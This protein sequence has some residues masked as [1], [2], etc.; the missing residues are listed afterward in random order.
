MQRGKLSVMVNPAGTVYNPVSV[1]NTLDGITEGKIFTRSDLH[2][3]DGMWL[4][5][6]HYSDFSSEDPDIALDKIN[7]KRVEAS[8]FLKQAGYLFITFGTARV[9]RWKQNGLIVSNCHKIPSDRFNH[10]LLSVHEIE[11]IWIRQLDKLSMLYPNL[12]IIFT[13]SPVRHLKD[14]AHGN[15]VSKSVLFLAVERLLGHSSGPLYF[16]AYEILMD[17]LRDYRFYDDD[18]VHPSGTA[19]NYIWDLFS[20]SFIDSDALKIWKEV[21][22]ITKAC[23]HRFLTDSK[24]KKQAFARKMLIHI[25]DMENRMPSVDFSDEKNY[26]LGLVKN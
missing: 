18:M 16:P 14:G 26:F 17:D 10:E 23:S 11:D 12:K 5:F 20:E 25:S 8:A 7:S 6:N 1:V 24:T 2:F 19:L 15:Q 4:S 22:K 3:H 9:F 13:I 21:E